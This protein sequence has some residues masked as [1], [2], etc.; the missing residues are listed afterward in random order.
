MRLTWGVVAPTRGLPHGALAVKY[1]G[2]SGD[3]SLGLGIGANALVGGSHRSFA[4]QPLSVE[5]Q[6]GL[7][8]ALGVA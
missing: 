2:A 5:G 4:V 7:N 1:A 8:L 6:V 3:I